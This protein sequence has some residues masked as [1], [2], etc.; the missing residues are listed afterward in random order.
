MTFQPS[1]TLSSTPPLSLAL[2]SLAPVLSSLAPVLSARRRR[3]S[4]KKLCLRSV[5]YWV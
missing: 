4:R 1:A 5:R 2:S 3:N